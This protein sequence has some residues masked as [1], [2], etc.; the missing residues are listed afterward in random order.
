MKVRVIYIRDIEEAKARI[1]AI[2]ADEYS[3]PLMAKKAVH[4]VLLIEDIDNRAANFLKQDMLSIGGETAVSRDVGALKKGRSSAL[5]MGTLR[6]LETLAGKISKQPFGLSDIAAQ[7]NF[8]LLREEESSFKLKCGPRTLLLGRAPVVMGVLNVTPD[9][10]SDGGRY[11]FTDTAVE[12]ALKMAEEGAG[13]IDIGGESTRPGSDK[14]TAS[15]ERRRVVPVI[16]KLART[17][18]VPISIDTYKPETARA[19][20]DAGA[21]IINDITAMRYAGGRMAGVAAEYGVPAVLMHMQGVPKTMQKNPDYG[22][23]VEDIIR[24]LRQRMDFAAEK[25]VK[26]ERL[27]IDPG[28]GFGKTLGHNLEIL[29]RMKE[30]TALG[31]PVVAGT[32]RKSFIGK[33]LGIEDPRGRLAGSL[34]SALWCALNGAAVIRAHDVRETVE[35]LRMAGAIN[36]VH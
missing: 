24:F 25:G 31:R 6:Q 15:E 19:A 36:G 1:R 21:G 17:L 4:K 22:D 3:V 14:V 30:F 16:K 33:A 13:I 8:L 7:M 12:R 32:S 35:A 23:V 9:S 2:G 28:I 11:V 34:S 29:K 20:L 27:L 5:V 18:K 10:F 26:P